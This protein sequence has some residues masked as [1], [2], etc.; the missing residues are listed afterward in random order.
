MRHQDLTKNHILESWVYANAAARTGASGFASG[1]VGRIAYQTD[2][3][4]YWRLASTAPTWEPVGPTEQSLQVTPGNPTGTTSLTGVH[5]GMGSSIAFTPNKT[6]K[7][8]LNISGSISNNTA[9]DG[10]KVQARFGTGAAPANA[11]APTGTASGNQPTVTNNA[12]TA[13][14]K[15]PFNVC[16]IISGLV[17][18]TAYW[19]DLV[20]SAITGGTA[21]ITDLTANVAEL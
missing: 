10:A 15:V 7:V 17:L 9:S 6:G 3:K 4:Q 21:T 5:M 11:A 8:Q 1:D 19:F 13:G 2:T 16:V 18:G 14:L 12:N 20:L